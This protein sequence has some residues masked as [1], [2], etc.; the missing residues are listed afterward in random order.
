[1]NAIAPKDPTA[2]VTL[3]VRIADVDGAFLR[4]TSLI[5]RRGWT[6]EALTLGPAGAGE[7]AFAALLAPRDGDRAAQVLKRQLER[8]HDVVAVDLGSGDAAGGMDP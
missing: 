3:T 2:A 8:L 7:K 6:L 5:E 1:M 4:A